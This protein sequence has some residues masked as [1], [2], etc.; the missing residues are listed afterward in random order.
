MRSVILSLFA[1]IT[2]FGASESL[3][4]NNL[5]SIWRIKLDVYELPKSVIFPYN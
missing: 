5:E 2:L 4:I 1:A 3:Q